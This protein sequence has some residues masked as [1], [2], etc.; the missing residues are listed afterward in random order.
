MFCICLSF[1]NIYCLSKIRHVKW[2]KI[3]V[4]GGGFFGKNKDNKKASSEKMKAYIITCIGQGE[5]LSFVEKVWEK[6]TVFPQSLAAELWH[7]S[8]IQYWLIGLAQACDILRVFWRRQH[9]LYWCG[10]SLE[11]GHEHTAQNLWRLTAL[12]WLGQNVWAS[13][14]FAKTFSKWIL[15]SLWNGFQAESTSVFFVIWVLLCFTHSFILLSD[16]CSCLV[17]VG[18]WKW[19]H[20]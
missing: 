19:N 20:C 14:L 5:C 8:C 15:H 6:L 4:C 7:S 9:N 18:H 13:E 16:F 11:H 17:Q 1:F 10:S 2:I 3:W 12:H